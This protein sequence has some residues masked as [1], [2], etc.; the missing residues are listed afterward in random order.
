MKN[1][2]TLI[3]S[4]IL[5][6]CTYLFTACNKDE[7]KVYA[8]LNIVN[9]SPNAPNLDFL[10]DDVKFNSSVLYFGAHEGY[11]PVVSGAKTLKMNTMIN[12]YNTTI[13]STIATTS[14]TLSDNKYHTLFVVD[15]FAKKSTLL[16]QDN[17]GTPNDG[18]AY[19]RFIQLAP[20]APHVDVAI[21]GTNN[22]VYSDLAF[23]DVPA[24]KDMYVGVYNLDVR[25][26]G[27]NI[28]LYTLP[29]VV[30]NSGKVYTVYTKGFVGQTG[31]Q[32]LSSDVFV[33][34][35]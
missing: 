23:K 3:S 29:A 12:V 15:S 21:A 19:F 6:A 14:I 35:W 17:F 26:A 10:L 28:V 13:D 32:A 11:L 8:Q 9:A 30:L 27:T 34:K 4:S 16:V 1:Q 2:F 33:N 31:K 7:T 24:F 25:S 20:N 18:H 5:L 22:L